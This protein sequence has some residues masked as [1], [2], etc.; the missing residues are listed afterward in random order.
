[1]LIRGPFWA[2]APFRGI[3]ATMRHPMIRLVCVVVL[4]LAAVTVAWSKEPSPP[5]ART[6][7]VPPPPASDLTEVRSRLK[8]LHDGHDHYLAVVP[9][10]APS[11]PLWY[12]DGKTMYAQRVTGGGSQGDTAFDRIFW[13]PRAQDRWQAGFGFRNGAYT[14]QCE[15]R[16]TAFLPLD[17]TAS[18]KIVE[19]ATFLDHLWSRRAYALARDQ[20][21]TYYYVDTGNRPGREHDFHLWAGPRGKMKPLPMLNVVSDAAGDIFGT[22]SGK[23]RLVLDRKESVW[24]DGKREVKL[25]S[26][27]VGDNARLIYTDLG[28]YLGQR[29]GTPCDDL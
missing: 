15:D 20:A 7:A 29:L 21:G 13:D 9:F 27:D 14:L 18:A 28:V 1:M 4:A 12:G 8:V 16:Q 23:L 19:S 2:R 25:T 3:L 26:L 11:G 24:I 22:K 17:A 5:A 6:P 10:G